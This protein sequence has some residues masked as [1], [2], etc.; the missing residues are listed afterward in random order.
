MKLDFLLSLVI[1]IKCD[2]LLFL[3]SFINLH[4]D[5]QGQRVRWVV[6]ELAVTVLVTGKA[7]TVYRVY[8]DK[9]VLPP[10]LTQS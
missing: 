1:I 6:G 9:N 4:F 10:L 5:A 8:I 2:L 3:L 7:L